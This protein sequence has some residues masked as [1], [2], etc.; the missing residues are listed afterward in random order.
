MFDIICK[1][2]SIFMFSFV[3]IFSFTKVSA[4]QE[5]IDSWS[6]L[7]F[8]T[9]EY[10]PI[11]YTDENGVLTG[12]SVEVLI[13]MGKQSGEELSSSDIKIYP[14]ARAYRTALEQKNVALFSTVRSP[15][16]ERH[17]HWVGPIT[18][19]EKIFL[20]AKKS[21]NI[22]IVEPSDLSK[23]KIGVI[24]ND[25]S[26]DLLRD[27]NV[28]LID[29]VSNHDPKLLAAQ[30]EK[31]RIDLWAYTWG[32]AKQVFTKLGTSSSKFDKV[33]ELTP[34]EDYYAINI[35][36]NSRIVD[37]MQLSLDQFKMTKEYKNII[38]K[39]KYK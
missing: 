25:I 34:N 24:R 39:Y 13:G 32:G 3:I 33:Y 11:N 22:Q 14:W 27:L 20:I 2:S 23:Y 21:T 29:I 12:L 16:R 7:N 17:F 30:L 31:G 4:G 8:I 15:E 6:E 36:T 9:E 1:I 5:K 28:P 19:V 18:E 38:E 37:K 35:H 26:E 10:A